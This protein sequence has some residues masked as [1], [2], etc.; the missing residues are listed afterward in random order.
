MQI[1][2][3][4][5]S[6]ARPARAPP[7]SPNS[8]SHTHSQSTTLA[9]A[10]HVT[11]WKPTRAGPALADLAAA[12]APP[13]ADS[14]TQ[15]D[16]LAVSVGP[17]DLLA[18]LSSIPVFAVVNKNN[19]IVLV[20][21]EVRRRTGEARCGCAHAHASNPLSF[22]PIPYHHPPLPSHP[23]DDPPPGTDP[24]ESAPA[25]T[26]RELG[27]LFM[28]EAG[29]RSLA[30]HVRK[31]APRKVAREI[32]VGRTTLDRVYT[33]AASPEA[34]PA[35]A[36][37]VMFRFVPDP[38]Q[39]ARALGVYEAA[40]EA[41]P[42]GIAGVP[43]FQAGGLSV[44]TARSR[45]TP[46]FLDAA[47]LDMAVAGAETAR[48]AAAQGAAAAAAAAELADAEVKLAA[49]PKD[50]RKRV[51]AEARL[52]AARER[53]AAPLAGV[54]PPPPPALEVGSLES[55]LAAMA[56]GG[57]N[58]GGMEWASAM[59]VP[60]GSMVARAEAAAKAAAKK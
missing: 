36:E 52:A 40:G 18:R 51:A 26:R 11:G 9:T 27:L 13:A 17:P 3:A 22:P 14:A 6:P 35:G 20:T 30:D 19:D 21:G 1:D 7:T 50:G 58:S 12:A 49:A 47:D 43:V 37:G 42:P 57:G 16:P 10:R 28:T 53:V 38:A 60:P 34:R 29:A 55:V 59:L 45:Y 33:L 24:A 23:Q 32:L 44:S 2:S 54:T 41:P 15:A 31:K 4:G 46:L 8:L 48:A 39:V 56:G 5:S 25:P